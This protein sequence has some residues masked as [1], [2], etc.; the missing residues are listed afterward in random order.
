[1]YA[2]RLTREKWHVFG[3]TVD[4]YQV[5]GIVC[6]QQLALLADSLHVYKWLEKTSQDYLD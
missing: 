5:K 3:T 1:M 2:I 6:S 4:A